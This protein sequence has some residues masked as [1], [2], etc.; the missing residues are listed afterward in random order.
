MQDFVLF[1]DCACRCVRASVVMVTWALTSRPL[2]PVFSFKK[3]PT[4]CFKTKKDTLLFR[5][6]PHR[7]FPWWWTLNPHSWRK[8]KPVC[9]YQNWC[10]SWQQPVHTKGFTFHRYSNVNSQSFSWIFWFSL[11]I[12]RINSTVLCELLFLL[13]LQLYKHLK[14]AAE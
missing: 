2:W 5:S 10:S 12:D 4:S 13:Q 1:C 11:H 8:S 9:M 6:A 3:E 7:S 14:L